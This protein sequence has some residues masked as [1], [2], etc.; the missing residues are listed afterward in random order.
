M[1]RHVLNFMRNARLL[2]PDTFNDLDQL[3]EEARYFDIAREYPGPVRRQFQTLRADSL[4]A[5]R[6]SRYTTE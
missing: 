3:L 2:I 5:L 6:T 1:F 4:C